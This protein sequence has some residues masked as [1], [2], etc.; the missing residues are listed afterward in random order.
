MSKLSY[1]YKHTLARNDKHTIRTYS[2]KHYV[3]SKTNPLLNISACTNIKKWYEIS[4]GIFRF[5]SMWN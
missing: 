5:Q 1:N 2:H 3:T 4:F